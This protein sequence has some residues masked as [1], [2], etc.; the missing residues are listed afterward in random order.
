MGGG[1]YNGE[2]G[3]RVPIMEEIEVSKGAKWGGGVMVW[4]R[5]VGV[6]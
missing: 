3:G 1:T 2:W 6:G 5:G 4:G